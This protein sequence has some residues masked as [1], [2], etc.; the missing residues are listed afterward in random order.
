MKQL[1][2][3]MTATEKVFEVTQL[4]KLLLTNTN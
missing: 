2:N 3:C 1:D 4:N